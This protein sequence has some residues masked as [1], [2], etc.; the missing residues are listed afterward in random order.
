MATLSICIPIYQL[1]VH[2]LV[3]HLNRLA[4]ADDLAF[5]IILIDDASTEAIQKQ[6]R[7]LDELPKVQY[8]QL[9]KNIGRSA[10]RNLLAKKAT[11]NFILFLDCDSRIVNNDF[12]GNYWQAKILNGVVC[13][14]RKYPATAEKEYALHL[15]YGQ[16]RESVVAGKNNRSFHS[17][18]FL[19][20]AQIFNSI[21]FNESLTQYGH[22]DTLFGWELHQK[23]ITV[24]NIAN[25]VEHAV[26]ESSA[27]FL[28][29]TELGLQNILK[30]AQ[31]NPSLAKQTFKM[32]SLALRLRQMGAAA[33]LRKQFVKR[34]ARW[35][36]QLCSGQPKLRIFDKYR[37][38][39]L[40]N[41]MQ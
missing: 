18:N 8:H 15:K 27:E 34:Q 13:G 2:N 17:N 16:E 20:D 5:E 36:A 40:L 30:I 29:K 21:Q 24:K 14:G 26:L 37:L 32:Y 33:V 25:P 7:N 19:I 3:Q 23:G 4:V 6:N 41:L 28:S 22:E 35:Q 39:Y 31:I 12:L 11:G 1:A 38:G 10:I 9:P